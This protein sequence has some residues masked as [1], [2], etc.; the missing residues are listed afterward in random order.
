MIQD[1]L[2]HM[3]DF[4]DWN[5]THV[6]QYWTGTWPGRVNDD[7]TQLDKTKGVQNGNPTQNGSVFRNKKEALSESVEYPN[8]S[9]KRKL[10]QLFD[11]FKINKSNGKSEPKDMQVSVKKL[12]TK[13]YDDSDN[14]SSSSEED[15]PSS[16]EFVPNV[17]DRL[18]DTRSEDNVSN[19]S[20]FTRGVLQRNY[21]DDSDQTAMSD[22]TPFLKNAGSTETQIRVEVHSDSSGTPQKIKPNIDVTSDGSSHERVV[23]VESLSSYRSTSPEVISTPTQKQSYW[24]NRSPSPY[25]FDSIP[26]SH[27]DS[28]L[29]KKRLSSELTRKD[30]D[31]DSR[32][33]GYSGVSGAEHSGTESAVKDSGEEEYTV[34]PIS[35]IKFR[36]VSRKNVGSPGSSEAKVESI[37][38]L[39]PRASSEGSAS[40]EDSGHVSG[41]STQENTPEHRRTDS[42]QSHTSMGSS[43]ISTVTDKESEE[44]MDIDE[45][46]RSH[47]SLHSSLGG[48]RGN[49][50]SAESRESIASYYSNA[51]EVDYGKIPITG[52]IQFGLDYNYRT[53]TLEI[54]ICQCKGLAPADTRRNRSDPY[55]KTYLLP[56]KTRSGK[57][58]TKIKKHTL[59]PVF[60]EKLRYLISKSELENRT[61]WVTVWHNDR[62]GRNDFL[63]EV[64]INFD[65]YRFGDSAPKWYKLQERF[66]QPGSLLTYKGDI[67]LCLKY[68]PPEK[69][70]KDSPSPSPKKVKKPKMPGEKGQLHVMI[71]EARNL[72]AVRSNGFSDPFCKGQLQPEKEKRKTPVIKKECN[73][74]W[75]Y[76]MVFDDV[77]VDSLKEKSLELTI[78]DHDKLSSNDF[79][80]GVRLNLGIGRSCGKIVDWMDARGE[81]ISLWQAMLD[82]P[83]CWIDGALVLRSTMSKRKS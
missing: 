65:Y 55:V 45:I 81:E 33:S 71:K 43:K 54:H 73:P 76:T 60:D 22:E 63:G 52:D 66:E 15:T 51:G 64:T 69:V 80:G 3:M 4:L 79:L 7:T 13:R 21:S 5:S 20:N 30:S 18:M 32:M 72:T 83:N 49:L 78:W 2:L 75:N 57:R 68:V 19:G 36:R 56:D 29:P 58:K 10:S 28:P 74:V 6:I 59:N 53:G 17:T 67:I 12:S 35:K 9:D 24:Q 41:T 16:T 82:R 11:T 1:D 34:E 39:S 70:N 8:D 48:S 47:R 42:L 40:L 14:D 46:V 23:R 61:V 44:D 62:F 31:T 37:T 25:S 50:L 27:A 26:S 77:T 38:N